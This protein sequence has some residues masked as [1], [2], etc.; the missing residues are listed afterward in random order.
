MTTKSHWGGP[1][2]RLAIAAAIIAT[3]LP[4]APAFAA[5][6]PNP[7]FAPIAPSGNGGDNG[8]G[9]CGH[10]SSGGLRL[11]DGGNGHLVDSAKGDTCVPEADSGGGV[12]IN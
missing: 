9:N 4:A 3:M 12:G 2:R 10:N 8:F 11:H 5:G 7:P 1:M 6:Q